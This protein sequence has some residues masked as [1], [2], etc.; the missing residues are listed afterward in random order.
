MGHPHKNAI[1]FWVVFIGVSFVGAFFLIRRDAREGFGALSYGRVT[2]LT[3]MDARGRRVTKD[4]FAKRVSVLH[5]VPEA[6]LAQCQRALRV[7]DRLRAR[8]PDTRKERVV[9]IFVPARHG[10]RPVPDKEGYLTGDPREVFFLLRDGLHLRPEE[11]QAGRFIL[12]DQNR[13]IRG[14]YDID[15]PGDL[16]KLEDDLRK[17][18]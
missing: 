11:T 2:S 6:C 15:K 13:V 10:R 9:S 16:N 4:D 14:Y 17:L 1:I 18:L 12:L 3:L 5:F 8:Y 7:A